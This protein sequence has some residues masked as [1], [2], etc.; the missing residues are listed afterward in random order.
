MVSA[1]IL[2]LFSLFVF[3]QN[4]AR[5]SVSLTFVEEKKAIL[6]HKNIDLGKSQNMLFS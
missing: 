4:K 2:I 1:K 6:D 5:S 3:K